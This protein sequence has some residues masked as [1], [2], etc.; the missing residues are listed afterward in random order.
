MFSMSIRG[1]NDTKTYNSTANYIPHQRSHVD[2]LPH[3]EIAGQ[4]SNLVLV[5]GLLFPRLLPDN[6]DTRPGAWRH[7]GRLLRDH[8]LQPRHGLETPFKCGSR[9]DEVLH[10]DV[11]IGLVDNDG[12][13]GGLIEEGRGCEIVVDW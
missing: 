10:V 6:P 1:S 13:V 2:V 3:H 5:P 7:L 4:Y 8:K 9:V 11:V 12:I